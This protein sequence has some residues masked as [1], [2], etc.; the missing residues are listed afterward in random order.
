MG[1]LNN[2]VSFLFIVC[3]CVCA[4]FCI[5]VC[6]CTHLDTVCVPVRK[7]SAPAETFPD[8]FWAISGLTDLC[9][10]AGF[11]FKAGVVRLSLPCSVYPSICL[12]S[13][14][15]S[16][17]QTWLR[18]NW[19]HPSLYLLSIPTSS[20][21]LYLSHP[22]LCTCSHCQRLPFMNIVMWTPSYHAFIHRGIDLTLSGNLTLK[23]ALLSVLQ[24]TA[25]CLT[26]VLAL[27]CQLCS[28]WHW[29]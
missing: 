4:Y 26:D 17:G 24:G 12:M 18:L 25:C 3:I 29:V 19:F 15:S 23:L 2:S 8:C 21:S 1:T 6:A 16:L 5:R 10:S 22:Y 20:L 13:S 27:L 11:V 7:M 9:C 14:L 28:I